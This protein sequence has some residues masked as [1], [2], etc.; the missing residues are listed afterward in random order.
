MC[1]CVAHS[2]HVMFWL[3][4][5]SFGFGSFCEEC[6]LLCLL[7]TSPPVPNCAHLE[8]SH[9]AVWRSMPVCSSRHLA[10]YYM[11]CQHSPGMCF[12]YQCTIMCADPEASIGSQCVHSC[13]CAHVGRKGRCDQ[14]AY[15]T[16]CSSSFSH[17]LWHAH[18]LWNFW[19]VPTVPKCD[20]T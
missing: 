9:C 18:L 6:L 8:R 4:G 11:P 20:G 19:K 16:L 14:R 13:V 3:E 2:C 7:L 15:L 5:S 10:H 1:V 12:A 17:L